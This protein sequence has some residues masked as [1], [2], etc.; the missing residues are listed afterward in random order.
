LSSVLSRKRAFDVCFTNSKPPPFLAPEGKPMENRN[1]PSKADDRLIICRCE[2]ISLGHIK[3]TIRQSGAATVNQLKKLT[4]AGMGPCQGRTCSR[5]IESIL[6]N[7]AKIPA[8][9][10]PY[11]SR[12]PVR[13][14]PVTT[15][16]ASADQFLEPAGPVSVVALR[17]SDSVKKNQK[18][19]SGESA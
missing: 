9:T 2:R 4:R 16:A 12:P 8:G 19:M 13:G 5:T 18:R 7:E 6:E 3:Q 1:T 17:A 10:E 14:V 11:R 15:L